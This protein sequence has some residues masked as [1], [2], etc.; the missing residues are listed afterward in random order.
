MQADTP[1]PAA[2]PGP[3]ARAEPGAPPRAAAY[4][5]SLEAGLAARRIPGLD[6]MRALG[7]FFVIAYHYGLPFAPG[8]W[9]VLNFLVLSGFLITWLLLGE[10]DRKGSIAL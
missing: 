1:P 4:P 5:A 9:G 8:G 7:S 2:A 6:G 10:E 3:A